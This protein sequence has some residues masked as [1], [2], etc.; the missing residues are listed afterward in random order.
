LVARFAERRSIM[1]TTASRHVLR[2]RWKQVRG[3]A[4]QWWGKLTG[5]DLDRIKG[6]FEVMLG[7][8]EERYGHTRGRARMEAGRF[9]NHF[10]GRSA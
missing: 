3:T 5:S 4:R 8:V 1:N 2:G 10:K 6:R 9:L 7:L